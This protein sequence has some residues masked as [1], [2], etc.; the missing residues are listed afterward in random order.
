M[1]KTLSKTLAAFATLGWLAASGVALAET[2]IVFQDQ[3]PEREPYN[4]A[5]IERFEEQNPDIKVDYRWQANEPYKTGIKVMMESNNPPDVYFVWAGAFA[6]DFV[7]TGVVSELS[8]SEE[9]GDSWTQG[10]A[11]G[12]VD[13]FRH[14]DGLYGVPA[15]VYTKLMWKN[16]QFF[17]DNNLEVPETLDE[18]IGLCGQIREIDP[19]MT[20]I[21]FGASESWT[22][23]HYL[24]ILFQRHVPIETALADY[25]LQSEADELFT[26]PGYE[27]A[28][29]DF[30]RLIDAQCFNDGI[31]S[32][33]PEVGRTMFATE[34]AAMNFCGSWCPPM[35][36]EQGFEGQYS[37]FPFPSVEGGRGDQNGALVGAQGYQVAENSQNKEAAV[38]FLSFLNSPESH[39]LMARSINRLPANSSGLQD[40]DLPPMQVDL[41]RRVAEAPVSVPPLNTIVETSV[42]DVILK[43]G[44]DLVAG[45]VTPAEFMERVREQA[46]TAKAQRG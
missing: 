34:L 9:R 10:A 45:T 5:V 24:T 46:Q 2:T 37:A 35:F 4:K 33:T 29:N 20:P 31:N 11:A 15:E 6:N 3:G 38:K 39:A 40:G 30:R 16:D 21:S 28:L 8:E 32:V 13:Q 22:I 26:D 36:D 27:A 44:Q 14:K 23:N 25:Q 43:S 1:S 12:V 17:A 42:S 19:L 7:D 41:L 18:L